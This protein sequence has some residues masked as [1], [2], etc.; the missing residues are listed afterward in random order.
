MTNLTIAEF[1]EILAEGLFT[2]GE[3][4]MISL[5]LANAE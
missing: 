2:E 4:E 3:I 1:N 5:E